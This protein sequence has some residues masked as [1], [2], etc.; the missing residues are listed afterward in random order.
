MSLR[1]HRVYGVV[2]ILMIL[3]AGQAAWGGTQVPAGE[4]EEAVRTFLMGQRAESGEQVEVVFRAVPEHIEVSS[5][6]YTMHVAAD[7]RTQWKGAVAVR[8]EI[9][10]EGR[11][12]HRCLV[13]VLI[14][15][16]ADVLVAERAI[17]RHVQ[18]SPEDLRT[19]RMETTLLHRRMFFGTS[20]LE[21]LRT[22]QIIP[23]GSILYED[24]LEP[25]PLVQ[26]GDRVSVRVQSGGV[27]LLTEGTARDDGENGDF[28]TVELGNR[29]DKVRGRIDGE[30]LVTV[31][32]DAGKEKR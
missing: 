27:L 28:V 32:L 10:S 9:E 4:L 29:R 11:I 1:V 16:Y 3:A 2:A 6:Q 15:T 5:D 31:L 20:S 17:E 26:R 18:P 7:G 14:R 21:G 19:V 22:R 30:R 24:L 25:I 12:V 8:V 13:S 23:R